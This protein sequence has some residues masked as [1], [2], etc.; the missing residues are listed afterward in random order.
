MFIYFLIKELKINNDF[1]VKKTL[2]QIQTINSRPR[3]CETILPNY[4]DNCILSA[5]LNLLL[6]IQKL[7]QDLN[8]EKSI[9]FD[10]YDVALAGSIILNK[11]IPGKKIYSTVTIHWFPMK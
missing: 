1:N 11:T 4:S 5:L 8:V 6:S 7:K 3:K 9:S 10:Y 2:I